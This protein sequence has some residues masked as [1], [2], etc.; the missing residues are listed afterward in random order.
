MKCTVFLFCLFPLLVAA[1]G[2]IPVGRDS[3]FVEKGETVQYDFS[4]RQL[5]GVKVQSSRT[6]W[7]Y[8]TVSG[9]QIVAYQRT[10]GGQGGEWIQKSVY[11][12]SLGLWK[13]A[14]YQ[15]KKLLFTGYYAGKYNDDQLK[16]G[17]WYF[18][19]ADEKL[20][21]SG[22]FSCDTT[23]LLLFFDIFIAGV[24]TSP[25]PPYDRHDMVY[26]YMEHTLPVGTWMVYDRGKAAGR[27]VDGKT[28]QEAKCIRIE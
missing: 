15:G 4:E 20:R 8:Y 18:Y 2:R 3:V 27:E 11:T 26:S 1:Q 22:A 13:Y 24:Y 21:M 6:A 10:T 28:L 14:C 5:T 25:K 16:C 23:D 9:E 17:T 7:C 12:D 19:G